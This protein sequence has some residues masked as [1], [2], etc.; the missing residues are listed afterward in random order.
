MGWPPVRIEAEA[1]IRPDIA[2]GAINLSCAA[3][4]WSW[5]SLPVPCL[6]SFG[7][8]GMV[9]CSMAMHERVA[10]K[11]LFPCNMN[12]LNRMTLRVE[13]GWLRSFRGREFIY[14][15]AASTLPWQGQVFGAVAMGW[16]CFFQAVSICREEGETP[17][18]SGNP[19]ALPVEEMGVLIL[20]VPWQS[21]YYALGRAFVES[22][23]PLFR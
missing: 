7:T 6:C 23:S 2:Y 11:T 10:R 12:D 17:Q 9:G 22:M 21:S 3:E 19:A 13:F 5:R 1:H 15:P 14:I 8:A 20:T 18:R 16:R 4:F